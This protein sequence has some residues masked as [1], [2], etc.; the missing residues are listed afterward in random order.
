MGFENFHVLVDELEQIFVA[1]DDKNFEVF[2]LFVL[3]GEAGQ[4][5]DDVVGFV[6]GVFKNWQAHGGAVAAH[7]RNL[8]RKIIGHRRALG[9]V[10]GEKL[11]A[12]S[13]RGMIEDDRE[14]V[15]RAIFIFQDAAHHGGEEIR[16]FGGNAGTGLQAVHRGEEGAEDV[17]HRVDQK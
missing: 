12:K 1:G 10:L 16:N 9:F 4:R 17:A 11:V 14:I 13:G 2:F 15:G 8:N 6:A 5:A 7:E 3:D